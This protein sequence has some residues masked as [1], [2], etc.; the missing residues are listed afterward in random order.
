MIDV[1]LQKKFS[2]FDIDV[3]FT[4]D[5]NGIT[6]LAGPSGSGKTSIINMIAGLTKPDSGRIFINKRLL[7]DS[8][9]K[10]D[11]PIQQRRCGYIFQEGRL[12]PHM[13]VRKNLLYGNRNETSQLDEI[14]HLL[15]VD[16]LLERMPGKL[17]GGEKQRVAIGRALLMQPEIL[18]MDEPLASL[19]PERKDELLNYIT[20]LPE[21]FNIPIFYVTHSRREILRLSDELIRVDKGR[22]QSSGKPEGEYTGLGT[23]ES[24]GEYLSVFECQVDT[25]D[26]DDGVVKATFPGGNIFILSATKPQEIKIRAAIRASDVS[27]SLE[28]PKLISTRNIFRGK[29]VKLEESIGHS[30]LV[31]ADT[32]TPIT[33][34]ISKASVRRLELSVGMDIFLLAKAVSMT[35]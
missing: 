34:R 29:I 16:H 1:K 18:L 30:V 31:H 26:Q 21:H 9:E 8:D 22:I 3:A 5:T 35:V 17:S 4:S 24:E 11:C 23:M 14:S 2:A 32:G 6:V 15:G 12:F 19:D 13:S 25:Y 33:A 28:E 7:F 20:R 10:V 27:I